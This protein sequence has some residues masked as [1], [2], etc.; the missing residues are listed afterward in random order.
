MGEK[1]PAQAMLFDFLMLGDP[2]I[3]VK[4]ELF[5]IPSGKR[6]KDYGKSQ[7]LVSFPTKNCD[8]P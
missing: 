8:F 1:T 2:I 7:F 5:S 3:W 6:T 4:P